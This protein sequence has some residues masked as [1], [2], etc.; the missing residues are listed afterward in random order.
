[1]TKRRIQSGV[2]GL[3]EMLNGGFL[4][5]SVVLLR[6][7]P[8][9]GKTSLSLQFLIHGA[10]VQDEPG[11]LITFEEFPSSLYR[12]AESLGWNLHELEEA[13]KLHLMFTSPEVF[14][15]GLET[16]GSP[17]DR[18]L[19]E[20]NIRRMV[21]DS[22]SH[23]NRL[24]NDQHQLRHIYTRVAN[25][26][27]REGVT[28][29]LLGEESQSELTRAEKGGLSFIVDSILL[30]R[31]VEIES[32]MQR[33]IVVLK[34]RGSDHAKEIRRYE[35]GTGGLT[36]TDVFEGRQGLLTG[37]PYLAP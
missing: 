22:V 23:F 3:D 14:L 10:T 13:R 20:G 4:P 35:I 36:V 31:Y 6:G 16:P 15:A 19:Q 1:V 2:P 29:I 26:L 33:A 18:V 12:D 24:N 9:T 32:A 28:S 5:S 8:G 30:L 25:G 17:V 27:R 37:I 34:M 11:L 7:A 21:L